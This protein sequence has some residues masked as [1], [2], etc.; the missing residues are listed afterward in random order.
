MTNQKTPTSHH[1]SS[2]A[3]VSKE[4]YYTIFTILDSIC[5][6]IFQTWASE[7]E[8]PEST[9]AIAFLLQSVDHQPKESRYSS[10]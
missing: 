7:L 6:L 9:H 2:I 4:F 10:E 5:I 8:S 3:E 1:H